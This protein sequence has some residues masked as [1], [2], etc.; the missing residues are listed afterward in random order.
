MIRLG[1]VGAENSHSYAIGKICNVDQAVPIRVPAIWGETPDFARAAAEK[2]SIPKVV[3][4][5]RELLGQVDAIMIDHRH[6]KH[7]FEPAEFFIRNGVPTFVDKPMTYTVEEARR[8]LDLAEA[9]HVPVTTFSAIPIQEP[10]QAFKAELIKDGTLR[11]LNSTGPADV[12]SPYGGIFFYGIHQVDAMVELM[13]TEVESVT[14][15]R[16][17]KNAIVVVRYS[18]QRWATIN[19][20]AGP[21]AFH[22]MACTERQALTHADAREANPY[23]PS[24]RLIQRLVEEKQSGF[25]RERM[26]APVA[27]LAAME[28]SMQSGKTVDVGW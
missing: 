2:G 26:I 15:E 19:C 24:A 22:W 27:V 3:G 25:S 5:W 6:A 21:A 14:A 4:D 13:G 16:R 28:R 12:D 1:I 7:H 11:T 18:G 23:L 9:G 20:L 17:G 10:F 8:L